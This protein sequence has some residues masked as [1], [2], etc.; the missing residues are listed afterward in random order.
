M[1]KGYINAELEVTDP[2]L[3]E[4][5]RPSLLQA[6]PRLVDARLSEVAIRRYWRE[7]DLHHARCCW[8]SIAQSER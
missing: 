3:F 4:T 2:A 8:S 1:P 6:L 7:V 5:Y